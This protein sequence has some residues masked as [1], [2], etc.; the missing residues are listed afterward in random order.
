MQEAF[1]AVFAARHTYN[2]EFSFRTWLWTILLNVCRRQLR[3]RQRRPQEVA[4]SALNA[5][6]PLPFPEPADDQTG[7]THALLAE[8]REQMAALLDD[9]PEVQADALRLRFYGG[10]KFEEIAEAMNCSLGGAKLRV[11]NGLLALSKR[12]RDEAG[13]EP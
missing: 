7:L 5:A 13:D 8:R 6:G 11:R 12:L 1:L 10:L 9:L 2:P 3:R 4:H